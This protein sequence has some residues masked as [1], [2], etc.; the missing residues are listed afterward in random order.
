M[1]RLSVVVFVVIA[2]SALLTACGG[3]TGGDPVATVKELA[4]VVADKKYEKIPDYLCAAERDSFKKQMD[5]ASATG[6]DLQKILDAMT[7]SFENPQYTKVSES[8]DKASVQMK[9]KLVIKVD[10][11][12]FKALTAEILKGQG[13]EMPEEQIAPLIEQSVAQ[14]EKGQDIDSPMELVKENGKW[15]VCG[16]GL[17][18]L[19][20]Q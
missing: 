18:V 20:I 1:K 8:G 14:I 12:K 19:P 7:I 11:E 17:P 6:I 3:G 9:T 5:S 4:Q 16:S 15:L 10:R 2:M 13:L